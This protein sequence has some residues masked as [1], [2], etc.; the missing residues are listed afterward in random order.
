[1]FYL[2]TNT[3]ANSWRQIKHVSILVFVLFTYTNLSL[4]TRCF[5]HRVGKLKL[6]ILVVNFSLPCEGRFKQQ[7]ASKVALRY[8]NRV[9]ETIIAIDPEKY[10]REVN[11]KV[12]KD[13]RMINRL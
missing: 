12:V 8:V 7:A 9:K 1:M 11:G 5:K 10:T 13:W 3:L 2:S 6:S 4:P